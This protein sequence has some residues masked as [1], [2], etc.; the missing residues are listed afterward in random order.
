MPESLTAPDGRNAEY[1]LCPVKRER[2]VE[3]GT[4][5]DQPRR[6]ADAVQLCRE[7]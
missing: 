5:L 3:L 1:D 2:K 7:T 6:C 4:K